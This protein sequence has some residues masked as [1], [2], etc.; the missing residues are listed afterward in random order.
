[1]K[2]FL[3]IVLA[4]AMIA[5]LFPA[6]FAL[7]K[8][9]GGYT[10]LFTRDAFG[11][12]SNVQRDALAE[13]TDSLLDPNLTDSWKVAGSFC[14]YNVFSA[15]YGLYWNAYTNRTN[16][17]GC[18]GVEIYVPEGGTY[19]PSL[20]YLAGKWAPIVDVYLVKDGTQAG[21]YTTDYIEFD[22]TAEGSG[23]GNT[24][25]YITGLD[26]SYKLKK[27]DMWGD[28]TAYTNKVTETFDNMELELES[29]KYYLLFRTVGKNDNFSAM[30]SGSKSFLEVWL[31][32]FKLTPAYTAEA[33]TTSGKATVTALAAYGNGEAV[34]DTDVISVDTA[35]YGQK[36]NVSVNE[37][38]VE[39][40][41]KTYNFLYWAKG[42]T[43]GSNKLTLSTSESF[44][45]MPQDGNN[46]LIAVYEEANAVE[47]TATFYNANGQ[48]LTDIEFAGSTLPALP[49]MAGYTAPATAWVQLGNDA[50]LKA[51][52]PVPETGDKIFMAKYDD[53]D[54]KSGISVTVN[55]AS[56]DST[57]TG[58]Y[59]YGKEIICNADTTKAETFMYWT[60]TVG[61]TKNAPEVVS[62]DESYSFYA[63]EDCEV[64]AVY[65]E[66]KPALAKD[67]R[68]IIISSVAA[69]NENAIMAEFIGFGNALEKGVMVNGRK[70][71]MTTTD[72]QFTVVTDDAVTGYAIVSDGNGGYKQITDK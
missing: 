59:A 62:M 16:G 20:T 22:A 69:G 25:Y 54:K 64:T 43:T 45:Y 52:D 18:F 33:Y 36:C 46:V 11:S 39:K 40:D 51:E 60:K 29:G 15:S 1:M 63:W 8:D 6:T 3:S 10:Y 13:I 56:S 55:G 4:V 28:T 14:L 41:G 38:T 44:D 57:A 58:T 7:A 23:Y 71:A 19:I 67:V 34:E 50:E 9:T 61:G 68:K 65:G 17:D 32:S 47:E 26:K 37:K 2:K 5:T 21:K 27:L 31:E 49:S 70:I 12:G 53:A 48:L 66:A 42:L 30:V 35:T 72:N 24:Y